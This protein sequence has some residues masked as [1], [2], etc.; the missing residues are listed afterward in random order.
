MSKIYQFYIRKLFN[1]KSHGIQLKSIKAPEKIIILYCLFSSAKQKHDLERPIEELQKTNPY[2]HVTSDVC[3]SINFKRPR[4]RSFLI[5]V[6]K[7]WSTKLLCNKYKRII[8]FDILITPYIINSNL[9][10]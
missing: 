9:L 7:D 8:D 4:L 10:L 6:T 3:S 5:N 2:Y 1:F